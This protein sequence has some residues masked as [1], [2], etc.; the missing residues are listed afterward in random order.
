MRG[1]MTMAG[2]GNFLTRWVSKLELGGGTLMNQ[3]K[4]NV[5]PLIDVLLV[6]LI[7]FMVITPVKP[8]RFETKVPSPPADVR[9]VRPHPDTLQVSVGRDLLL[10]V[11]ATGTFGSVEQP[12]ELTMKLLDVFAE[13]LS[14]A[15]GGRPAEVER[16]VFVRAPRDISYG[17]VAKVVD[18]V[19]ASGADPISLSIDE[20]D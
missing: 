13:R 14:N 5:T 11:N 12:D 7:I 8:S 16:T 2:R 1:R 4:I 20:L 10:R 15:G 3:P 9:I 19:K 18:A 17:D 6:L